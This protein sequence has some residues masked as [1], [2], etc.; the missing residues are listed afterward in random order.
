MLSPYLR[1]DNAH[2]EISQR[3]ERLLPN[4]LVLQVLLSVELAQER[5][6]LVQGDRDRG[7]VALDVVG[8][9][10]GKRLKQPEKRNQLKK[11]YS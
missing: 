6:G 7:G 5:Q 2:T 11:K 3:P 1:F 8:D 9:Q 10:Q 4:I